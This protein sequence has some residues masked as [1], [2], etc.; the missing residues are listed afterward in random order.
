MAPSVSLTLSFLLVTVISMYAFWYWGSGKISSQGS[1][2][3]QK[4]WW[5]HPQHS[6]GVGEGAA[7]MKVVG[8]SPHST[9]C[10]FLQGI[11]DSSKDK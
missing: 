11:D 7:E 3:P 4:I 6:V 8:L 5:G 10:P 1:Q 2:C 9:L